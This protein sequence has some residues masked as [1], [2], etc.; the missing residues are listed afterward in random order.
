[1][2]IPRTPPFR[3]P[4]LETVLLLALILMGAGL[5]AYRSRAGSRRSP[6]GGVGL[7]ATAVAVLPFQNVTG[8][9]GQAYFSQGVSDEIRAAV[10][11]VPGLRVTSRTS[12]FR[13]LGS[14]KGAQA[15]ARELGVGSILEG[16]VQR[17][18]SRV[19]VTVSLVDAGAD[20]Q[21]WTRTFDRALEPDSLFSVEAE[22]ARSVARALQVELR[23]EPRDLT[24]RPPSS[25]EAHDLYLLGLYHWNRRT[26]DDLLQAARYFKEAVA[27][28]P[29]YAM[30]LA[31]LANTYVLLP[32]YARV[33][34]ERA[35]P[36]ARAAAKAALA[37]DSSLADARRWRSCRPPTT[38]IGRGRRRRSGRRSR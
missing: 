34:A 26:G 5:W 10:A 20:T 13:Y 22:I 1:M 8:D 21:L 36:G 31:G 23:S 14:T 37:L 4:R 38:G 18:A 16:T 12:S 28:D 24:G 2:G 25:L 19:R 3:I 30:A 32:L 15:I 29:G 17:A 35:M 7:P 9:S 6:G 33:P 11:R 27:R